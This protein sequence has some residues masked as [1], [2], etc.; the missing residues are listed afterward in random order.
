MIPERATVAF[1]AVMRAELPVSRPLQCEETVMADEPKKK[2]ADKRP[3]SRDT[4]TVPGS[5]HKGGGGVN[6]PSRSPIQKAGR[7][8]P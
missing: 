8:R 2:P 6:K 1:K 7:R 3:P 5:R 4:L